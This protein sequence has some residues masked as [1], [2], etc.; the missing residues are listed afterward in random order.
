MNASQPPGAESHRRER[1]ARLLAVAIALGIML[2]ASLTFGWPAP[3]IA[4]ALGGA[5]YLIARGGPA[6]GSDARSQR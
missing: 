2:A 1:R 6:S 5:V 3:G 4:V